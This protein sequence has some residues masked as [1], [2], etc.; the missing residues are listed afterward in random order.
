MRSSVLKLPYGSEN[1]TTYLLYHKEVCISSEEEKL[2]VD[3]LA[4]YSGICSYFSRIRKIF[5]GTGIQSKYV[6]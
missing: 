5:P 2:Y 1:I 3:I 4:L 6:I